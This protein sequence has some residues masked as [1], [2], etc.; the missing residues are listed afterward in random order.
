M[1]PL[2]PGVN[3][4]PE[5]SHLSGWMLTP[6]QGLA[7]QCSGFQTEGV[8]FLDFSQRGLMSA[9]AAVAMEMKESYLDWSFSTGGYK[10]ARKT[11]TR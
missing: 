3:I 7:A 9:V 8:C 2:T 6:D 11:F 4:G 5:W 1:T 10:K